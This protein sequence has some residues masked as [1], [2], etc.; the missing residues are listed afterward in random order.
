[1]ELDISE[2]ISPS[3]PSYADSFPLVD[4][5]KPRPD[6]RLEEHSEQATAAT[7]PESSWDSGMAWNS[8]VVGLPYQQ[9]LE[10]DGW[11]D[12]VVPLSSTEYQASRTQ[13]SRA[14]GGFSDVPECSMQFELAVN[15]YGWG[16][17]VHASFSEMED[18][19]VPDTSDCLEPHGSVMDLEAAISRDRERKA[20]IE[21]PEALNIIRVGNPA[22]EL[23][24]NGDEW[25]TE[26]QSSIW[27]S[28]LITTSLTE[29]STARE[30][31]NKSTLKLLSR[32]SKAWTYDTRVRVMRLRSKSMAYKLVKDDT[33]RFDMYVRIL[34]YCKELLDGKLSATKREIFYRDIAL[35]KDQRTVDAIVEDLACSFGVPRFCL[36]ILASSKG[37]IYGDLTMILT[38]GSSIDCLQACDQGTLIPPS[39]QIKVL[40]TD[41]K[42]VLVIE[43]EATFRT[44]LAHGFTRAYGPCILITGKGYPDVATRQIVH[45][46]SRIAKGHP[47]TLAD[48]TMDNCSLNF[49]AEEQDSQI[50]HDELYDTENDDVES[51]EE[52][53]HSVSNEVEWL[54]SAGE[55]GGHLDVE[56]FQ[57]VFEACISASKPEAPISSRGEDFAACTVPD[58]FSENRKMPMFALVDADPHGVEIFLC[59]KAGSKVSRVWRE[60]C[61]RTLN[62]MGIEAMAFDCANL[63]CPGLSWLGVRPSHWTSPQL[64]IDFEKLLPLTDGDKR[65]ARAMLRRQSLSSFR[66]IK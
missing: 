1:M 56:G 34:Q 13:L 50:Y 28:H 27:L 4:V 39:E 15:D 11:D 21:A 64:K 37:L 18:S 59:Y 46:L 47:V 55:L 14:Y 3:T 54:Q 7:I 35:F 16:E 33:P 5:P 62:A 61:D 53:Q 2:A 63:S 44:L 36:N 40:Q 42:F 38:N 57:P 60:F 58:V 17:S 8:E 6:K 45:R 24:E 30:A 22:S 23:L 49:M 19:L 25:K 41:A 29:I 48:A 66:D 9:E 32:N 10:I 43:K 12:C 51:L 26:E 20:L 31:G 52:F 65:K